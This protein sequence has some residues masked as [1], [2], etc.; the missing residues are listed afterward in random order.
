MALP[1]YAYSREGE[2]W[3][4]EDMKIWRKV[5]TF[6]QLKKATLAFLNEEA[7]SPYQF[8]CDGKHALCQDTIDQLKEIKKINKLGF[9]TVNSQDG[10][11]E[12]RAYLIGFVTADGLKMIDDGLKSANLIYWVCNADVRPKIGVFP[13]KVGFALTKT[14]GK[15][16]GGDME[17]ANHE[18]DSFMLE[19]PKIEPL[20]KKLFYVIIIDPVWERKGYLVKKV[21]AALEK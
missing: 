18:Y 7:G 10:V 13:P 8:L 20:F 6:K 2:W 19:C 3:S 21:I 5:K 15:I 1:E 4:E 16:H 9:V 17:L 11:E 14:D 12:Q